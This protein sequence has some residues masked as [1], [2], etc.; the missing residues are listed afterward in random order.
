MLSINLWSQLLERQFPWS[1]L[2]CPVSINS[3]IRKA[4][5]ES[6]LSPNNGGG[7]THMKLEAFL[8]DK[9]SSSSLLTIYGS[10]V[11]TC[12]II[13]TVCLVGLLS[14]QLADFALLLAPVLCGVLLVGK[15]DLYNIHLSSP[16]M[17]NSKTH[18]I[19]FTV[20]HFAW[21]KLLQER[22]IKATREL[23]WSYHFRLSWWLPFRECQL[24]G[25]FSEI[26][27]IFWC[28]W[29]ISLSYIDVQKQEGTYRMSLRNF[30]Y[31]V[32]VNLEN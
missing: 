15:N 7:F 20:S 12:Y 24:N 23:N 8:K 18:F 26:I 25:D 9:E 13:L 29:L 21:L 4:Y 31:C 28:S 17:V 5:V 2:L 30:N 10:V 6:S 32:S 22:R 27:I 3:L 16:S 11:C 19:L 14:F 1:W